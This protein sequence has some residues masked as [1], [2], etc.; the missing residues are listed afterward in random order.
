M[1]FRGV[2]EVRCFREKRKMEQNKH[3]TVVVL[4]LADS[5]MAPPPPDGEKNKVFYCRLRQE[6]PCRLE[7]HTEVRRQRKGAGLG[8]CH[9][10]E[11]NE[12]LV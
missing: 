4:Y 1:L 7:S 6:P 5:L 3:T 8:I 11:M 10:L 12:S 2:C 9:A